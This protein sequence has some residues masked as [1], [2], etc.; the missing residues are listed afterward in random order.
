MSKSSTL[1]PNTASPGRKVLEKFMEE[2][3]IGS[4]LITLET[5]KIASFANGA[6]VMG[7]EVTMVLSTIVGRWSSRCLASY[8]NS[9]PQKQRMDGGHEQRK[10]SFSFSM[11][12]KI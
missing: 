7:M 8:I 2:F 1:E 12:S 5:G 9:N 6:I 3:E 11:K 10:S 4:R